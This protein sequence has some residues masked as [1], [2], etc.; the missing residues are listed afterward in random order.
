[1]CG[2]DEGDQCRGGPLADPLDE[3]GIHQAGVHH[4]PFDL[5]QFDPKSAELD[6]AVAPPEHLQR[7]AA[8]L[9]NLVPRA[10]HRSG[11]VTGQ[12]RGL[13]HELLGGEVRTVQVAECHP[14]AAD[15]EL[16]RLPRSNGAQLR[17]EHVQPGVAQR[18][19]DRRAFTAC[20]TVRRALVVGGEGRCLGRTV[21]IEQAPRRSRFEDAAHRRQLQLFTADDQSVKA[22][23][24]RWPLSGHHVKQRG[25]E[26]HGGDRSSRITSTHLSRGSSVTEGSTM[27]VPPAVS[28]LHT[29]NVVASKAGLGEL[30]TRSPGAI[31]Q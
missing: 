23:E 21:G 19:A 2:E 24:R 3:G 20:E 18:A 6:L 30:A 1:L 22:A 8:Q 16:S 9:A 27:T 17:V 7:A 12:R 28:V 4:R 26:E 31:V 14:G 5:I 13:G 25:G 29:S 11:P 10:V 15:A